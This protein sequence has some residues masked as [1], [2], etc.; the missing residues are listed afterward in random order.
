MAEF[1][2]MSRSSAEVEKRPGRRVMPETYRKIPTA[3]RAAVRTLSVHV[4]P[5]RC[6]PHERKR[7]YPYS[8]LWAAQ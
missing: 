4:V 3:T 8:C 5:V 6:D 1:V 2:V 7:K